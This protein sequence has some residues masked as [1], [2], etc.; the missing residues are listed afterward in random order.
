M[1][2][3]GEMGEEIRYRKSGNGI[4]ML[5]IAKSM[6]IVVLDTIKK[7]VLIFFQNSLLKSNE[8]SI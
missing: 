5:F 7:S 2:G 1:L 3:D 4:Y 8:V 6:K